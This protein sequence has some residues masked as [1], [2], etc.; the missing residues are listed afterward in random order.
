MPRRRDP[1][2]GRVQL[3]LTLRTVEL[4]PLPVLSEGSQGIIVTDGEPTRKMRRMPA[5]IENVPN[6]VK[7]LSDGRIL[8]GV[9][10]EPGRPA[11]WRYEVFHD[12]LAPAVLD[13][14]SR[15]LEKKDRAEADR[16]AALEAEERK[17]QLAQAQA[18][19]EEQRRRADEKARAA[20]VLGLVAGALGAVLLLAV[21]VGAFG[22]GVGRFVSLTE[23]TCD[24]V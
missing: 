4:N 13:W 6:V 3:A 11:A 5:A 2:R 18:L 23:N 14:R 8:R 24:S 10:A 21:G 19:A 1:H 22:V 12:V 20:R 9:T 17:R 15:Y 7:T 16:L